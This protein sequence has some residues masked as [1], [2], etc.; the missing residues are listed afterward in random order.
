ML[1]ASVSY[2]GVRHQFGRPIGS[3]QAVEHAC[4]DKLVQITVCREVLASA[5]ADFTD[6]H[7]EGGAAVSMA[8]AHICGAAVDIA[9]KAMQLHGGVG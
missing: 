1:D 7:S 6:P 8:K 2:A 3:F 5:I 4:A 9:G